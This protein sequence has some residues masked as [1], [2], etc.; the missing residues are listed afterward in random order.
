MASSSRGAGAI[1][2]GSVIERLSN[3]QNLIKRD[4]NAYSDEFK[5]QHRNFLAEL[6]IFRLSPSSDAETFK[7]LVTFL[8]HVSPCY[9]GA[10]GATSTL[11]S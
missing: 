10:W 4:S 8:S 1:A 7:A 5:L 3:L 2:V 9:P 11:S 6:D